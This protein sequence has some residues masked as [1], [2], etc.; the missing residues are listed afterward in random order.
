MSKKSSARRRMWRKLRAKMNPRY[1]IH[2]VNKRLPIIL[3]DSRR[4]W[5]LFVLLLVVYCAL[6]IPYQVGGRHAG[7]GGA[8]WG[9]AGRA[10]THMEVFRRGR[11]WVLWL[12][13]GRLGWTAVQTVVQAVLP[14]YRLYV[15]PGYRLWRRGADR[16]TR[17][18]DRGTRVADRGTVAYRLWYQGT[19]VQAVAPWCRPWYRGI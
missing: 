15:V 10:G 5:D 9:G 19:R 8:R 4:F 17:V 12:A 14:R 11:K 16:G 2:V 3:P 6:L 7:R 18:A 13:R 1:W